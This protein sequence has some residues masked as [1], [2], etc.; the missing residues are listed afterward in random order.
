MYQL[1]DIQV[2]AVISAGT[3][4]V[5]C[6]FVLPPLTAVFTPYIFYILAIAGLQS[7][8]G[9]IGAKKNLHI[10]KSEH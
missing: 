1:R 10:T 5:A 2:L 9:F 3:L 4:S 6:L 7:G 8:K